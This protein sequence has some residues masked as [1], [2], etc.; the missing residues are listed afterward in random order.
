MNK[1]KE[2]E[3]F[4]SVTHD[5]YGWTLELEG[6][7]EDSPI[8]AW[9]YKNGYCGSVDS[10]VAINSRGKEKYIPEKVIIWAEKLEDAFTELFSN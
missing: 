4:L 5:R 1:E 9:L 6:A 10:G 7:D 8:Q 2:I 3:E